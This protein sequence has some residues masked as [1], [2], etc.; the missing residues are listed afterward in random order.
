LGERYNG[1][2]EVV[3]SI[4][5]GST[6]KIKRLARKSQ[7]R[8]FSGQQGVSNRRNL[9]ENPPRAAADRSGSKTDALQKT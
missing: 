2:V 1:I 9:A 4:P 5:S 7:A 3:G 6:N 8:L